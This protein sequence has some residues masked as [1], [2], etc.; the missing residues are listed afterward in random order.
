MTAATTEPTPRRG[1]VLPLIDEA[2]ITRRLEELAAQIAGTVAS[3][4]T[5][6]ALLKGSFVFAADLV[7]ALGRA[8]LHPR[9]DFLRISSYGSG[10]ESSGT[11]RVLGPLPDG[12]AGRPVLLV[13]DIADSGRTLDAVRRLLLD[14]GAAEVRI[15]AL[16]DKPSR[17]VVPVPVDFIGFTVDDVFVVGYG[18]DWAED[19][20][21]L[22][23]VGRVELP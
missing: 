8:G 6:V 2:A 16:L 7:R 11:V 20:R 15:C 5:V 17:R 3:D 14:A 4:V 21:H 9:V 19:Y 13:D 23:F 18:I 1:T 22:P 12:V 10:T